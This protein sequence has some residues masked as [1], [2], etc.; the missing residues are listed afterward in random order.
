M[1]V[2]LKLK[3]SNTSRILDIICSYIFIWGGIL[4]LCATTLRFMTPEWSAAVPLLDSCCF[5]AEDDQSEFTVISW[6][7]LS[8]KLHGG[9]R[10]VSFCSRKLLGWNIFICPKN[11]LAPWTASQTERSHNQHTIITCEFNDVMNLYVAHTQST[12]FYTKNLQW[13]K[14]DQ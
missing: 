4:I 1:D 2:C 11:Q 5:W 9:F 14:L 6:T 13:T 7:V 10:V 12:I 8:V 3:N